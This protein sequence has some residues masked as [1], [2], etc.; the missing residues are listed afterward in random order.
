MTVKEVQTILERN[1]AKVELSDERMERSPMNTS[2]P[3]RKIKATLSTGQMRLFKGY[4]I[5][6]K[7]ARWRAHAN[8]G[9]STPVTLDA[10]G[11]PKRAHKGS[12]MWWNIKKLLAVRC[13]G[14]LEAKTYEKCEAR[15]YGL[16]VGVVGT[17]PEIEQLFVKL[18]GPSKR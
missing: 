7:L 1:K 11:A 2:F 8:L 14:N 12:H 18:V 3:V 16:M 10:L 9:A 5:K 4:F 13:S 17:R 15:D 6:G